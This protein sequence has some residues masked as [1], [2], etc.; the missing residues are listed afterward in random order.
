[1]TYSSQSETI[2]NA[3]IK[4]VWGA[5]TIPEQVKEWFFGTNMVTDW[6][7]GS[8]V[9]FKGEWEGKPYEDKGIVLEF[10]PQKS[11]TYSYWS[12]FGG[13]PDTPENYQ[14]VSYAVTEV[15]GA[16]KLTISQSNVA[17]QE[18]AD[19]SNENW[20]MVAGELAKFLAK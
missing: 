3:P 2:I 4:K 1:M 12:A 18:K 7:V 8:P 13:L 20:K 17:T 9:I 19:H 5:L 10:T 6:T 16:T 11:L 15:D 14:N